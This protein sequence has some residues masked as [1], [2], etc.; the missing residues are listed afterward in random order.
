[1]PKPDVSASPPPQ[2]DDALI[3]GEALPPRLSEFGLLSGPFGRAPNARVTAYHLNT[4]LFSDYA[5]KW[6]YF[7]LPKGK[8]IGWRDDGVLDFPVGSVLVKSFGYP[9][10]MRRPGENIRILETRLLL[11]RETGWVALPY[12]W[13]TD[14]S[15]AMLKRA[16]TRIE[17][18]WTHLDGSPRAIQCFTR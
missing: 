7:Y 1:M 3:V 13:N 4:P 15:D 5:E 6:R 12:V 17:V 9:A 11:H 16:G 14:G 2:V 8:K 10:D 18:R